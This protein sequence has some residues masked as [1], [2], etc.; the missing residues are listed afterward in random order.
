MKMIFEERRTFEGFTYK[1]G[2]HEVADALGER[3]LATF[4]AVCKVGTGQE[5]EVDEEKVEVPE[6]PEPSDEPGVVPSQADA[7]ERARVLA[8]ERGVDLSRVKGTGSGG[9]ITA[10]DV[11]NYV[12][13]E[14]DDG[15]AL[16]VEVAS[17]E[18]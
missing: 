10:R 13:G 7:T 1:P 18:Q 16:D 9:R 11:R 4:P 6:M 5:P 17:K 14:A 2:E 8:D 15:P 12:P 3:L